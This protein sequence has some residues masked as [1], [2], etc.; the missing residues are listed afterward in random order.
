MRQKETGN[1]L[2]YSICASTHLEQFF[3]YNLDA[4]LKNSV[5]KKKL[6]SLASWRTIYTF[7][8]KGTLVIWKPFAI[9]F[10]IS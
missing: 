7:L 9:S 1:K 5:S 8:A 6:R 3:S 10:R 4:Q 2:V